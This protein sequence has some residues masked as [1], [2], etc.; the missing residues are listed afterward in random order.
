MSASIGNAVDRG[1][2]LL[3][4]LMWGLLALLLKNIIKSAFMAYA[5]FAKIGAHSVL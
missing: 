4:F 1:C 2:H 3:Q 5:E